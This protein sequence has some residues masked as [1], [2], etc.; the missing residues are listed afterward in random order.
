MKQGRPIHLTYARPRPRTS[1][2]ELAIAT[3]LW[4]VIASFAITSFVA[5]MTLGPGEY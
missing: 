4:V 2:V 1:R 5:M 3:A